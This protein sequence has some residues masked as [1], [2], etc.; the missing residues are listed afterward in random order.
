V[1]PI[2]AKIQDSVRQLRD[3]SNV[4]ACPPF[5]AHDQ[6]CLKN[7]CRFTS[8]MVES[9]LFVLRLQESH[10]THLQFLAVRKTGTED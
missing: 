6:E 3:F 10:D 2:A 8:S 1:I 9:A 7:D 4:H 5:M